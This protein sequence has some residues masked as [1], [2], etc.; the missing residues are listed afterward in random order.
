[1]TDWIKKAKPTKDGT[2]HKLHIVYNFIVI[3]FL[4]YV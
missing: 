3:P 1:L 4:Y 2:V